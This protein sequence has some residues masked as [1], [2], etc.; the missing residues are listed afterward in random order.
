MRAVVRER[1]GEEFSGTA[2]RKV[3]RPEGGWY[4]SMSVLCLDYSTAQL[5]N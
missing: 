2:I 5:P 1:P 3:A 4:F